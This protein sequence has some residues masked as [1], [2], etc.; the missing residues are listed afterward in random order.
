MSKLERINRCYEYL[1]SI[2][3]IHTKKDLSEL[4]SIAPANV[5]KA[6]K[7][8]PRYLTDGFIKRFYNSFDD[9]IS[10]S[11]LLTGEGT[12]LVEDSLVPESS[13]VDEVK[14]TREELLKVIAELSEAN[15]KLSAANERYSRIIDR[16]LEEKE[17]MSV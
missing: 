5:T 2:G 8:D 4:L 14:T 12:M 16:L 3:K 10:E 9:I 7:G 15:N 6:F 17:A 1:R 11:W 13:Q